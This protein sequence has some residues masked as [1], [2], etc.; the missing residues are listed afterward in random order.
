MKEYPAIHPQAS[1]EHI[2][3]SVDRESAASKSPDASVA[4]DR[5]AIPHPP[6]VAELNPAVPVVSSASV[7][8]KDKEVQEKTRASQRSDNS[9]SGN[10]HSNGDSR[11][12]PE[13]EWNG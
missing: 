8:S 13:Y 6:S 11:E 5:Q 10:H 1:G 9:R 2:S 3:P 4:G 7:G 12:T